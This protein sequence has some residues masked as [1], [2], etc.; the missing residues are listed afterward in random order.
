MD[1]ADPLVGLLGRDDVDRA[2]ADLKEGAVSLVAFATVAD[3][4]VLGVDPQGGIRTVRPFEPGEAARDHARQ[5]AAL[6]AIAARDEVHLVCG[7]E[8]VEVA[9]ESR[10][11]GMLISCEGADFLDG[12]PDGMEEAYAAGVRSVT[13]VHYRVNELGD[14]QTEEP[15]HGGLTD[16]GVEVVREMNRLGVIVDLAHA[17]FAVTKNVLD[18]SE[19]PVMISHSHLARGG[20]A[21]P[22]L[23]QPEHARAVVD[24]GGLIGAWPAGVAL[25]SF[26]DYLDEILRLV[27]FLG[28]GHV[29]VGTDM[30]ANYRPVVDNYTQYPSIAAG[31]AERGLADDEV[32]AV[33]GGNFLRLFSEVS[34]RRRI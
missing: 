21:H 32:A 19:A 11:V 20:D 29:A 17:T 30:D 10:R 33:M 18:V 7:P 5:I 23:L 28:V 27:D 6:H 12:R 3:L 8:D 1:D 22:R 34:G 13:L 16:V 24:H 26:D 2:L 31:L 15:V 4:R 9:R 25:A 14:I